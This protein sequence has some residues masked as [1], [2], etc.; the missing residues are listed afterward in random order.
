MCFLGTNLQCLVVFLEHAYAPFGHSQFDSSVTNIWNIGWVL[1]VVF[2][3][4]LPLNSWIFL[5][6]F[7]ILGPPVSPPVTRKIS[8]MTGHCPSLSQLPGKLVLKWPPMYEAFW[9]SKPL[10][11]SST[12]SLGN[13]IFLEYIF[14]IEWICKEWKVRFWWG[15]QHLF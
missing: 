7:Q 15:N 9:K 4:L 11:D 14:G 13:D 5:L 12:S 6:R 2:N 1:L 10:E 3:R 8:S